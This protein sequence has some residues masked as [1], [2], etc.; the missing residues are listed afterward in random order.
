MSQGMCGY[1]RTTYHGNLFFS[2]LLNL[3][4][5]NYAPNQAPLDLNKKIK[6]VKLKLES[7]IGN[8]FSVPTVRRVTK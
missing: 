4:I 2:L 5:I 3:E 7:R 1:Q 6:T 8:L